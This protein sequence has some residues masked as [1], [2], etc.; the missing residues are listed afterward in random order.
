MLIKTLISH[1]IYYINIFIEN[2]VVEE[3]TVVED[4]N[5]LAN[6]ESNKNDCD[7]A[8]GDADDKPSEATNMSSF[9]IE[10]VTISVKN[11]DSSD[12]EGENVSTVV[13]RLL[14]IY[15]FNLTTFIS[16]KKDNTFNT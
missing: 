14:V 15:K 11:V 10:E 6:A 13:K 16:G 2:K 3:E 9:V 4:G 8:N 12:A 7:I 1:W 5:E